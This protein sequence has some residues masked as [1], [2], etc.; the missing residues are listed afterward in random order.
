M[1]APSDV[2]PGGTDSRLV[3]RYRQAAGLTALFAGLTGALFIVFA[4]LSL[5]TPETSRFDGLVGVGLLSGASA[6]MLLRLGPAGSRQPFV[7]LGAAGLAAAGLLAVVLA[8]AA[9]PMRAAAASIYLATAFALGLLASG[10]AVRTRLAHFFAMGAGMLAY[11]A[12]MTAFFIAVRG[13]TEERPLP[14]M[15]LWSALASAALAAGA[16]CVR[17][18]QGWAAPLA[19]PSVGGVTLRRFLPIVLLAVPLT[20]WLRLEFELH[21]WFGLEFGIALMATTGITIIGAILLWSA[22]FREEREA[23]LR[24][25]NERLS[26]FIE[27]APA[28]L[29]MF[30]REMR[31][32]AA[33]RR[34]LQDFGLGERSI[35]G[36][37]HYEVF[38]EIPP[39]WRE[40]HAR[41]LAGEHAHNDADRFERR[42]GR[43]QHTRWEV[44]PW[45]AADGGVGGIV[46]FTEDI[47]RSHA[48]EEQVRKLNA[49]LERRV[50]Q[51]TS[52]LA[53]A[54]AQA[55]SASLAKSA[56]L[57]NMSHEIR[58]PM[59]AILGLT[60][61]LGG[62]LSDARSKEKLAKISEA[63][64]HLLA[65]LNDVLDFSKIEAGKVTLE[66]VEFSPQA[67]FDQVQSQIFDRIHARGLTLRSD[68]GGLPPVLIGDPVRL[69]Q[70]LLNYLGNAIK[71]TEQGSIH[72][73]ARVLE[74]QDGQLLVRFEVADTGVGI[75]EE[76][77]AKL[78]APFEQ[79]DAS[80]SRRHQGSGLGLAITR[81]LAKLM[82]GEAG[83]QSRVGVGSTF[84]FT[85][86]LLRPVD[87]F[88]HTPV[89]RKPPMAEAELR[90]LHAGSE[91]L[92]A[93]DNEV[94]R[95]VAQLLLGKAG[96]V[97]AAASDGR[98]A[99]G[100][101]REKHYA[102]V[103]MDVQMPEMDGLEATR[104][105][106]KLPGWAAIPIVAMTAN[107]FNEDRERC[108]AAGM[109]D[110]LAKPV[111]PA[112]LYECLL[113]WLSVRRC[114][115]A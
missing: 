41:G 24:E 53:V 26:L 93:E 60:H 51:R 49:D 38:P 61:L 75:S 39:R 56:F 50:E 4:V 46:I 64:N 86:R 115:T 85:A 103:L 9:V 28:A 52:E 12:T 15:E 34:W 19:S 40:I 2:L 77:Q 45:R 113:R 37:S 47:T 112:G 16:V 54:K 100:M 65:I 22:S 102:L 95:D 107:A 69:K 104:E 63:A 27:H 55:E 97:V 43:V 36:V 73:R 84:W 89:A 110:H 90:R 35:L 109:N 57:A 101:A 59:N 92:L 96:L 14:L 42:D 106:R 78:F 70:S 20:L 72:L 98:E 71:F 8:P 67:L 111:N 88:V 99:V 21:G 62:E 81:R 58:T 80:P 32:V 29:A 25:F 13:W 31:Y 66:P 91:V 82:G 30:D 1:L 7:L 23:A 83:V 79:A 3:A 74:E 10:T 44:W 68:T 114:G 48:A 105:I 33:S 108:F 6:L 11:L 87:T 5:E 94:N 18:D 76:T 17:I